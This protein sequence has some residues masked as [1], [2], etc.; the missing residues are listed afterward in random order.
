MNMYLKRGDHA[1]GQ[2]ILR[3]GTDVLLGLHK[4]DK[5]NFLDKVCAAFLAALAGSQLMNGQGDE[6]RESLKKAKQLAA[7]FDAAPSYDESDIRFISRIEGASAHDDLGATATAG[8]ELAVSQFE[9]EEF[10]ALWNRIK[11][12]EENHRGQER[13]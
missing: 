7:F 12:E 4:G 13:S 2:A 5:P 8:V 11:K 6:A 3:W 9:N 1:S 10:T